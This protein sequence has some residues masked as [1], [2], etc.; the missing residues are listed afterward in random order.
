MAQ[1]KEKHA[2][3]LDESQRNVPFHWELEFPE[4]FFAAPLERGEGFDAVIGNPPYDV[5]ASKEA[6]EDLEPLKRY[7]QN[8]PEYVPSFIGKNNLYKLFVCK[9]VDILRDEG[10]LGFIVP[11]ALLGDQSALGLRKLVLASGAFTQIHAFPQKDDPHKRV[12]R[13]AKLSTVVFGMLKTAD[14]TQKAKAFRSTRY[15]GKEFES[16][17]PSLLI[18]TQDLPKYDPSNVTIVSCSQTDWDLAVRLMMQGHFSRLGELCTQ[19]QGEVN[20]TTE[21]GFLSDAVGDGQEVLRG[22]SVCLYAIREASQGVSKY[23]VQSEFLKGKAKDGK[24]WHSQE[25]RVGFQ[26]SAPQNNF[27]RIIAAPISTGE[28]CFDTISYI[29]ASASKLGPELLLGLLNS[30]LLEWY[31]RLGSSNSKLNE[32]Q[33]DNLPCPLFTTDDSHETQMLMQE[34]E[35]LITAGDLLAVS[36]FVR[37]RFR[38]STSTKAV[39]SLVMSRLVKQI[40]YIEKAR[41]H[42]SKQN[43]ARLAA[44]SQTYQ[45]MVDDL[46]TLH[47]N[48]GMQLL[49]FQAFSGI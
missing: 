27:R 48:P 18:A 37:M 29:P 10:F 26:R 41:G 38:P 17:S 40:I 30:Q 13:D 23:I 8:Q 4:V 49:C 9:A 47:S 33:F 1:L 7:F 32:Y 15:P 25:T 24:S 44:E 45:T 2:D 16:N 46:V 19:Y 42:V 6:G 31:F 21:K 43:R 3:L 11:M 5:I 34:L 35:G 36:N 20:E 39:S 22:A 28:F 14:P 12:F